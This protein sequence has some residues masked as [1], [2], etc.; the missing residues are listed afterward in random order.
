MPL[1]GRPSPGLSTAVTGALGRAGKGP[2]NIGFR[3]GII[4][5]GAPSIVGTAVGQGA[6]G[7]GQ[8]PTASTGQLAD[9]PFQN[10][11]NFQIPQ[12]SGGMA[13]G[14]SGSTTTNGSTG[15]SSGISGY[16]PLIVVGVIVAGIGYFAF[17]RKKR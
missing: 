15:T 7:A 3:S 8:G 6:F 10:T 16:L 1:L 13:T 17:E 11:F 5:S 2:G 9:N 14:D 12:P 4:P